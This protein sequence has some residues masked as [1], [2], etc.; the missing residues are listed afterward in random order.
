MSNKEITKKGMIVGAISG[1][2][3]FAVVGLFPSSFIGGVVGLKIARFLFGLS[4]GTEI[5]SRAIVGF[6]MVVG[7]VVTGLIFVGGASLVG[8]LFSN[9]RVNFRRKTVPKIA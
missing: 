9:L 7:I 6:S 4:I 1:L 5:F 8:W 2:I 3:L